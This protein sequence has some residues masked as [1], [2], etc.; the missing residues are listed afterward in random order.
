MFPHS[1]TA[2]IKHVFTAVFCSVM[3]AST[4]AA[5]D[6]EALVSQTASTLASA[7]FA[8]AKCKNI[9]IDEEK[10]ALLVKRTG[11]T[12]EALRKDEDYDDQVN[13]LKSVETRSGAAM[14]CMVLPS[15]H[16]G[17]GRGVLTKK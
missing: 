5:S 7:D 8:R 14:V 3:A 11:R 4:F 2:M 15:A 16:G 1:D 10:L 17:Y 12:P 9:E 13:A 6:Q